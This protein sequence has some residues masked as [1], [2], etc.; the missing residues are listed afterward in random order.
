ME[1]FS[2]IDSEKFLFHNLIYNADGSNLIGR[3]A[4]EYLFGSVFN[5]QIKED[6]ILSYLK[7]YTIGLALI[8]PLL[9]LLGACESS[10]T[11]IFVDTMQYVE[12]VNV[13][14][15]PDSVNNSNLEMIQ[16]LLTSHLYN[17]SNVLIVDHI[18]KTVE[19][20]EPNGIINIEQNIELEN[21]FYDPNILYIAVDQYISMKFPDYVRI[22]ASVTCPLRIG[23]QAV[24]QKG[25][26][27]LYTLLYFYLRTL[28]PSIS[29]EKLNA[30]LIHIP[31]NDHQIILEALIDF[32]INTSIEQ[33]W[34]SGDDIRNI[35]Y[36]NR[37]QLPYIITSYMTAIGI[38][39]EFYKISDYFSNY[40]FITLIYISDFLI[41]KMK[42]DKR[43][44]Q[45]IDTLNF[46]N[47][48]TNK[49]S[50]SYLFDLISFSSGNTIENKIHIMWVK[51][52]DYLE[53]PVSKI[54]YY[55]IYNYNGTDLIKLK[56]NVNVKNDGRI[57]IR[58]S[59]ILGEKNLITKIDATD[60][61]T[62]LNILQTGYLGHI[63]QLFN[64]MYIVA[65]LFKAKN[66]KNHMFKTINILN[67]QLKD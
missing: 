11:M 63:E 15:V 12:F 61:T 5:L 10:A 27:I 62:A 50:K 51:S 38:R 66:K 33:R 57:V 31:V 55:I 65:V 6:D 54:K 17:H 47:Y 30:F 32:A 40:N 9:S 34:I 59:K 18:N 3:R 67:P 52:K 35:M 7:I 16:L 37:F 14:C 58:I 4:E 48:K 20:Y 42:K 53:L 26:C 22:Q 45:Y 8:P 2:L 13:K 24:S 46:V 60:S 44:K 28:H 64:S 56:Y 29:P 1:S 36:A 49:E 43:L 19:H 39:R 21:R 41:S 23:I 25:W